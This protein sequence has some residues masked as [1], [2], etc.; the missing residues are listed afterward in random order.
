MLLIKC[1][2]VEDLYLLILAVT[3]TTLGNASRARIFNKPFPLFLASD[4][5]EEIESVRVGRQSE[6]LIK[7]TDSGDDD[8]CFSIIFKDCKKNLDLMAPSAEKAKQWVNSLEKVMSNMRNLNHQQ[9]S[10]QYPWQMI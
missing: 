10:E 3:K 8:R 4:S 7:Y 6:G 5:I 2:L 1:S 9:K